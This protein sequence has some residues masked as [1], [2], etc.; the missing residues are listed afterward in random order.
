MMEASCEEVRATTK[1]RM[2][3]S[4]R[5]ASTSHL[6][7]V[8][9]RACGAIP[10]ERDEASSL[11]VLEAVSWAS[12]TSSISALFSFASSSC[13]QRPPPRTTLVRLLAVEDDCITKDEEDASTAGRELIEWARP[14]RK[15]VNTLEVSMASFGVLDELLLVCFMSCFG[16]FL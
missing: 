12:S 3:P 15:R 1:Q 4:C 9:S 6:P 7:V 8:H 13:N 10:S 5:H 2:Y 14:R 11:V 16:L